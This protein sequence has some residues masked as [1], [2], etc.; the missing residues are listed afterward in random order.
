MPLVVYCHGVLTLRCRVPTSQKREF[1][2]QVQNSD[3]TS[4]S[5]ALSL[6]A[7]ADLGKIGNDVVSGFETIF[8]SVLSQ[9]LAVNI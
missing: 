7:L 3:S 1:A 5:G 8:G 9:E 4:A 2:R 6:S